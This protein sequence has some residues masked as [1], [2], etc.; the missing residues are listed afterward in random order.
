MGC[1]E[2]VRKPI[3]N[4]NSVKVPKVKTSADYFEDFGEFQMG[5]NHLTPSQQK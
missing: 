1:I 2:N 4:N 5:V 3:A